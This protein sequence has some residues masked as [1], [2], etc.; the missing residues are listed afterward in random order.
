MKKILGLIVIAMM[1]S[2]YINE[3]VAVAE[4]RQL[5]EEIVYQIM[6]D[7]FNNGDYENDNTSDVDNPH[8]Y[9]GGDIEGII[10]KLDALQEIGVSTISLSPLMD[11]AENGYHGYLIEDFYNMEEQFGTIDD[12]N[13]LIEEA[14]ARGMKV[15][16]EF[17]TS[18]VARSNP[19]VTDAAK[20]D[21]FI[22]HNQTGPEWLTNVATF[23]LENPEVEQ[24]IIDVAE[25][26]ISETNL[27]G[28]KL[29]A[30]DQAPVQFL[31]DL[32][33]HMKEIKPDFY[34]LGDIL[35][36]DENSGQ[37]LDNTE[38]QAIENITLSQT[39]RDVFSEP[40][41]PVSEIYEAWQESN[42]EQDIL[43]LDDMSTER[44]TQTF[45]ENG[46][47]AVTTWTLALT[48]MYT[49]PGVPMLYQGS[50]IP[51]YGK[52]PEEVQMLVQFN[53]GEPELKEFYD[54]ISALRSQFPALQYGDFEMVGSSGAM[55]VFKRT[56]EDETL[57]IA[58]NN[59]SESQYIR[60]SDI[61]PGMEL[62]GYLGDNLVREEDNGEYRIGIPRESVE[63]YKLQSYSGFNW[64]LIGLAGGIMAVFIFGIIYLSRKQKKR[65]S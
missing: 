29:H 48:Y 41:K 42:K 23:N 22:E 45:S 14:H 21:W 28:F 44:F 2:L 12:L 5:Q 30:V 43:F 17:V 31:A 63:V 15:V 16:M 54:R 64:G 27:D 1:V 56:Y 35:E 65:E 33:S 52:T 8:A 57:F 38:I 60:L 51:M 36:T 4:E 34:L 59:D 25:F 13:Q 47:N 18:Y 11:N 46:R 26:W 53:S 40:D 10:L 9:H 55:S 37:I 32:T 61:E 50:E 6:V 19:I 39:M 24:Y 58:I 3:P 62:R 20:E 49:T 7:R